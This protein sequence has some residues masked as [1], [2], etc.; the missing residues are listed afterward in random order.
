MTKLIKHYLVKPLGNEY[1][2]EKDGIIVSTGVENYKDVNRIGVVLNKPDFDDSELMIGDK[3]VVHHNCFRTYY[4]M[5]GRERKSSEHFRNNL[6]L[7]PKEK[8]Y[9]Y[10]RSEAWRPIKDYCFISPADYSQQDDIFIPKKEEEHVGYV[11]FGNSPDFTEGDL[12]GYKR[13]R[14]YEFDIDGE[15]LYR[16]KIKDILVNL[17]K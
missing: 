7:I 17:S 14:E 16:M 1:V 2:N 13:N 10:K 11:R 15:K 8:I 9:L 3:C 4:D 6:Y 12:V 5:Q